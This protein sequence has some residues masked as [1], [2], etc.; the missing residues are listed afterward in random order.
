M[1]SLFQPYIVKLFF[2]LGLLLLHS[3]SLNADDFYTRKGHDG[4]INYFFKNKPPCQKRADYVKS[5]QFK[6]KL[7]ASYHGIGAG[8]G[9]EYQNKWQQIRPQNPTYELFSDVIFDICFEYG[10]GRMNREQ[11]L[12]Q[13]DHYMNIR[14]ELLF[15]K[16]DTSG[17]PT[18]IVLLMDSPVDKVVYNP[19]LRKTGATNADEITEILDDLQILLPVEKT[20][21]RWHRTTQVKKLNPDLIVIHF[22]A[23]ESDT[24]DCQVGAKQNACNSRFLYFFNKS[25]AVEK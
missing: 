25:T 12:Q 18:P 24:V 9:G 7:S 23:F 6:A 21:L 14:D 13:R 15:I 5:N 4:T 16:A 8:V 3:G 20:S 2:C 17:K 19:N 1:K 10:V 22:S 11:Y